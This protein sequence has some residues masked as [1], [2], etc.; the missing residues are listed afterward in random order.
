MRHINKEEGLYN[1]FKISRLFN[2]AKILLKT[3]NNKKKA[4]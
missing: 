4:K 2:K 3:N 1:I